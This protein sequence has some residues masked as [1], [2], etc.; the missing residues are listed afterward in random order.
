MGN[1]SA[2]GYYYKSNQY[3]HVTGYSHSMYS[4]SCIKEYSE[5]HSTQV[6]L[7]QGGVGSSALGVGYSK[8]NQYM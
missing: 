4:R 6:F 1:Q 7:Y 3:W 2:S 5:S 8:S